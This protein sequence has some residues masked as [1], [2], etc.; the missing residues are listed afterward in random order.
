MP[1][2]AEIH[3]QTHQLPL[4]VKWSWKGLLTGLHIHSAAATPQGKDACRSNPDSRPADTHTFSLNEPPH[5]NNGQLYTHTHTHSQ[6]LTHSH[7]L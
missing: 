7:P 2:F 4:P 5:T 6:A 3:T 1:S